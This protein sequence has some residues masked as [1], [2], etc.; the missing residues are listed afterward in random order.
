MRGSEL[1]RGYA[2]ELG[3]LFQIPMRGSELRESPACRSHPSAFQIP[4]RG[5]E[6]NGAS[7]MSVEFRPFQIPMRGSERRKRAEARARERLCFRSP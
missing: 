3:E 4:M 6:S 1:R 7:R 2:L 5:S